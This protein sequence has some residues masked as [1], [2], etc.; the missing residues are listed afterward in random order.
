MGRRRFVLVRGELVELTEPSRELSPPD[1][2]AL[3][4]DRSYAGLRATDGTD[5][6]TRSKHREYMRA[7]GL[8]T[9]DDFKGEWDAAARTRV[10]ELAGFDPT[11]KQDLA[12]VIY[13]RRRRDP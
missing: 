10:A 5:I 8:T 12:D 13:G 4:G 6:S 7:R 2:G 9:M 1:A 3:W 11:R